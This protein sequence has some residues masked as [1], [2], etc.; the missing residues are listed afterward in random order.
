MVQQVTNFLLGQTMLD[1]DIV[2]CNI[3]SVLCRPGIPTYRLK[4][5]TRS[6][7][8]CHMPYNS[9]S[10]FLAQAG[11]DVATCLTAPEPASLLRRALAL[12]RALRF[13]T[14]P[15]C[16][17]GLQRCHVSSGISTCPMTLSSPQTSGIKKDLAGLGM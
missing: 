4:S 7:T 9:E 15:P 12:S 14:L 11:S 1:M 17:R 2:P 10:R 3:L 16:S 6:K 8:Y 5:K 13:R